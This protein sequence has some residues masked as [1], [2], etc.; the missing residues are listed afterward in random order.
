LIADP[1]PVDQHFMNH[2]DELFTKPNLEAQI[3]L[4]NPLVLE[5]HLQCAA[6]EMPLQPTDDVYFGSQMLDITEQRMIKDTNGYYHCHPRFTPH[7]WKHV[8]IRD[9]EDGHYVIVD[10]THNRNI[11]LEELEPSRTFFTV[12]EGSAYQE[13]S[14]MLHRSDISAPG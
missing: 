10:V 3:D 14:L 13:S 7:P 8:S 11:V 12:F 1:Y 4:E 6:Y 9:I 2:P 5:G